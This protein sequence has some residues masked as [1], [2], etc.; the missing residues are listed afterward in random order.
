M[1][2]ADQIAVLLGVLLVIDSIYFV[3]LPYA[4][5]ERRRRASRKH[6]PQAEEIW[7]QDGDL[8]Y[9]DAVSPT[10]VEI[11]HWDADNRTM[12]RWKDTWEEWRE[13]LDRRTVWFTGMKKPLGT[14]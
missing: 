10:G 3:V 12:N 4:R 11:M 1:L 9:I 8:L 13:R 14:S 2:L 5:L 7:V 6:T